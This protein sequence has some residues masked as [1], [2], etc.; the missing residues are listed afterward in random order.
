VLI[1]GV[2]CCSDEHAIEL[3]LPLEPV[4]CAQTG[5]QIYDARQ[6]RRSSIGVT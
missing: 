5:H 2:S 1:T 4:A 6:V 3:P